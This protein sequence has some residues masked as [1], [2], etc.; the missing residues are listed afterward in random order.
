MPLTCSPD[1]NPVQANALAATASSATSIT[2]EMYFIVISIS[3]RIALHCHRCTF[4]G[5]RLE[6][7]YRG[8]SPRNMTGLSY[9]SR[10]MPPP[11]GIRGEGSAQCVD[12]H[13]HI[14]LRLLIRYQ[15]FSF[16]FIDV[17]SVFY[18]SLWVGYIQNERTA[19]R[20]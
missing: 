1:R 20:F 3:C 9:C 5:N 2:V 4:S 17:C 12:G 16:Y 18:C 10:S 19:D 11:S 15:S 13:G 14:L 8:Y 7:S 6:S